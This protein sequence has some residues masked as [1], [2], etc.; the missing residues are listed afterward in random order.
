[1]ESRWSQTASNSLSRVSNGLVP[2][3]APVLFLEANLET[4]VLKIFINAVSFCDGGVAVRQVRGDYLSQNDW[5]SGLWSSQSAITLHS[6]PSTSILISEG[7][8]SDSIV[9]PRLT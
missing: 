5:T 1:M 7:C 2:I 3:V 4:L 6:N 8:S 9:S